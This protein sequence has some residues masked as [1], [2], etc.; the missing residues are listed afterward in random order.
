VHYGFAESRSEYESWLRKGSIVVSTAL[1]E[2][3]GLAV[4][5]AVRHGCLPLLPNRLAY[6]EVLPEAFHTDFIYRSQ[7]DLENKLSRLI[8]EA[9]HL[10]EARRS[11]SDAMGQYAWANVIGKYDDMLAELAEME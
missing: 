2:N 5:E 9:D 6:P 4:V 3:F 1:Q 7:E 8:T 11:L 10:Q